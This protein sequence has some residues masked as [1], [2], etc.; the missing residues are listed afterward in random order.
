LA[1]LTP[2]NISQVLQFKMG[3]EAAEQ[4]KLND[5]IDAIYKGALTKEALARTK[6]ATP[7]I[8]IPGT[9]IKLTSKQYL[10]WYKT[11]NKDER[12]AAIKNYEYSKTKKGGSSDWT[13]EEFYRDAR[14]RYQKDYDRYVSEGGTENFHEWLR[15]IIALGGGLSLDEVVGRKKA[16]GDLQGQLYFKNPDWIDNLSKHMSSDDVRSKLIRSDNPDQ[17]R[18]EEAVRFI[19]SK[20]T[21]GGGT[22]EDVKFAADG[23][24]MIWT[25]KW[26]SGNIEEIRNGVRP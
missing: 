24:T 23:K 8:T 6:G 21:A 25:V 22:I 12:T 16:L 15:D 9:D 7:S 20:I 19:E 18:A 1:G 26:P 2:E 4:Q 5:V 3:A 13:F 10:D 17:T 11:A 14:T